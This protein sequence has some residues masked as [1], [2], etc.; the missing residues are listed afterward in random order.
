VNILDLVP[1]ELVLNPPLDLLPKLIGGPRTRRA[2]R[3]FN[4][5]D[6]KIQIF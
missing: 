2:G 6:K 4:V 3:E 1:K 5:C